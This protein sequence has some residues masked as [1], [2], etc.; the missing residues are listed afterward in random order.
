MTYQ[1]PASRHAEMASGPVYPAYHYVLRDK[2]MNYEVVSELSQ[3]Q[4]PMR[5]DFVMKIT[6]D[7]EA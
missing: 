2:F 3:I 4:I 6:M 5:P 7:A 1:T